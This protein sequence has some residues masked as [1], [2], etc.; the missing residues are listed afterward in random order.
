VGGESGDGGRRGRGE[1]GGA[2]SS[3]TP[4]LPQRE[5][6]PAVS[7][8]RECSPAVS[9]ERE[10]FPALSLHGA[11]RTG[12]LQTK[13]APTVPLQAGDEIGGE[14]DEEGK[15]VGRGKGGLVGG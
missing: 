7:V 13:N 9:L 3:E 8:Q 11:S 5:G 12:S 4:L 1:M 6:A 10:C 15:R 2:R 14:L